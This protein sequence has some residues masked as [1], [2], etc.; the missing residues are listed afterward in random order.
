VLEHRRLASWRGNGGR[1]FA[2]RL[3]RFA[4]HAAV[5]L[6]RLLDEAVQLVRVA[7]GLLEDGELD[8]L[9]LR[10][11][12]TGAVEVQRLDHRRARLAGEAARDFGEHVLAAGRA[13]DPLVSGGASSPR[14]RLADPESRNGPELL[15]RS[16]TAPP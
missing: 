6:L 1:P 15:R 3:R 14:S 11:G 8:A 9:A 5:I 4:E 10:L 16:G 2:G 12:G 7:V 13:H